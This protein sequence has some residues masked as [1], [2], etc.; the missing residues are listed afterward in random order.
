MTKRVVTLIVQL[1]AATMPKPQL[2]IP[3]TPSRRSQR[4]QPTAT[5]T[6]KEVY[7]C[8]IDCSW[9][10]DPCFVRKTIPELDLLVAERQELED[11][12]R[13]GDGEST[14]AGD[15]REESETVFY[16]SFRMKRQ[17]TAFRGASR[18]KMSKTELQTYS[19]GDTVM[20]E[21][22][23]MDNKKKPPSVGVIVS[24]WEVR[25]N[26]KALLLR[27]ASTM[28]VRVHWF[29][30]QREL[31]AIRAKRESE[32]VSLV[33]IREQIII[34]FYC[35]TKYTILYLQE[36]LLPQASSLHVVWSVQI[37]KSQ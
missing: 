34:I 17:G 15:R 36:I 19:V 23:T 13:G 26:G 27:D 22:D 28:R 3:N 1:S 8:I 10:G 32:E 31:A 4:F 9:L 21:T 12:E 14:E 7:K 25:Q 24:M 2:N 37:P 6:A 33:A 29:L 18:M 16:R 20:V 11:Q 30:R 5:P 35:R